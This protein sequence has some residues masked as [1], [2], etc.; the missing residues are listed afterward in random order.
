MSDI[1]KLDIRFCA[2]AP[3]LAQ[4]V[5]FYI[6][7]R[8]QIT[9][10]FILHPV[11]A[12]ATPMI[13]FDFGDPVDVCY[14]HQSALVKSPITVVVGPQTHRR[15]EMRLQ[16]TLESFVIMFQP[17]GLHRL[18]STP[19]HE[20]TDQDYDG[21]SVLGSFTAQA[22]QRLGECRSFAERVSLVDALLLRQSTQSAQFDGISAAAQ[23]IML[24]QGR[25][26]LRALAGTANLGLRQFERRF[27]D[28]VGIRPKLFA[29][30]ARFEASLDYKARFATKSWADVAHRFGYYDQM[31]MVHDFAKFTG[32]S[33]T[34]ILHQVETV[35]VDQIRTM[36]SR[37]RSTTAD[38][39]SRLIL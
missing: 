26:D 27:V 6:H 15:V 11:P 14:A 36:R 21:H 10:G 20:L 25:V 18:F 16:G 13:E 32:G 7:R 34:K 17:D 4:F 9:G 38:T 29:R 19:M 8:A 23:W 3:G 1:P 24:A 31:H 35:Y 12:R 22:R 39:N 28:Q 37:N 33:P 5:R 2:P 30:I